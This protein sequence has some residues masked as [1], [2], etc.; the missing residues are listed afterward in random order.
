MDD[1]KS[2]G[3]SAPFIQ[4]LITQ[5]TRDFAM[6]NLGTLHYF[7]GIQVH[8]DSEGLH[9]NQSKY[10]ADLLHQAKMLGQNHTLIH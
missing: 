4:T 10:T 6:K 8:R 9:L 3:S 7:L 2:T 1:F 5:L